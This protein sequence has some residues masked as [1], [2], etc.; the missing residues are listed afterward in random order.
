MAIKHD[1]GVGAFHVSRCGF[2][3]LVAVAVLFVVVGFDLR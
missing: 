1:R 2:W 3:L